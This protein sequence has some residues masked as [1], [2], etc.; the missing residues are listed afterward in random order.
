LDDGPRP[1][2]VVISGRLRRAG[3]VA[4]FRHAVSMAELRDARAGVREA[5]AEHVGH[6]IH[7]ARTMLD[8]PHG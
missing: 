7:D 1:D 6:L 4:G 2:L 8:E 5:I 3:R